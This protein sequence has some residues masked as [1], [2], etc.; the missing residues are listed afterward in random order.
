MRFYV[1]C[2]TFLLGTLLT[3]CDRLRK[4][5]FPKAFTEETQK[6]VV[7][8][9][10]SPQDTVLAARISWSQPLFGADTL[11]KTDVADA[12]VMLS[13]GSRSVQLSGRH[14]RGLDGIDYTLYSVQAIAFPIAAGTTYTLRVSVPDGRSV[15]STCTVP[16]AVPITEVR[17]DSLAYQ[18]GAGNYLDYYARLHWRD[19]VGQLNYYRIAGTN[20]YHFQKSLSMADPGLFRDGRGNWL[21]QSSALVTDVGNDGNEMIFTGGQLFTP[22]IWLNDQ[23]QLSRPTGPIN[24]YLLN[25]DEAYYRYHEAIDR[26]VQSANNPFAEPVLLPTNIQGG[27]GC[28][29]AYNRSTV[30]VHLP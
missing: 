15:V 27:L 19:P 14:N 11:L 9:F 30:T 21:F 3:S 13:D 4:E 28:F 7:S 23:A 25:T 22:S 1:L 10:I 24:A 6:L 18:E 29:G 5:V 2:V 8:C 26:Q 16:N 12:T 17:I 20:E